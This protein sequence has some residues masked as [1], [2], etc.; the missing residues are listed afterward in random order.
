MSQSLYLPR[1][2]DATALVELRGYWNYSAQYPV[3]DLSIDC[4]IV[5]ENNHAAIASGVSL[6]QNLVRERLG[7]TVSSKCH[8]GVSPANTY[9]ENH[10]LYRH[11]KDE[12]MRLDR[13]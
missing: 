3:R 11:R 13:D 12:W 10:F 7:K 8:F 5:V 6:I 1:S 2:E 4:V 9:S